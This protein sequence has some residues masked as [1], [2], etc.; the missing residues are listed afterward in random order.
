MHKYP[1]LNVDRKIG[2]EV[3]HC[4]GVPLKDNLLSFW[5]WSASDLVG[6]TM[7]G[8]LAEYIVASSLGVASG[9]R[10]AWD[11]YD[12]LT[13]EGVKVEVKS[14]AYIQTWSQPKLSSIQFGISETS[15][16]DSSISPSCEAVQRQADVYV[17]C[18]LTHKDQSTID[19]LDLSQWRF[20]VLPTDF[21]NQAVG[22]Q[23][24]I[25]LSVLL[26]LN[27]VEATYDKLSDEIM[28]A[29]ENNSKRLK[30]E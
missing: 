4:E 22:A 12:I 30:D 13:K 15:G 3:F 20:Y 9:H 10:N 11:A 1:E 25:A 21:L 7:R 8:I 14:A 5:Q 24:K 23:K 19:P 6:N 27:P 28:K 26:R 17:F 18:V 16:W 2:T 29:A